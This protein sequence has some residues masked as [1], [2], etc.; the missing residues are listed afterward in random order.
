MV[1]YV[2]LAD[3]ADNG[4]ILLFVIADERDRI[5]LPDPE[6]CAEL[7]VDHDLL[8]RGSQSR[9]ITD[10]AIAAEAVS[11]RVE[12]DIIV[13]RIV[14]CS[15]GVSL[16]RLVSYIL[17]VC[18]GVQYYISYGSLLRAHVDRPL[19][20][21]RKRSD[22]GLVTQRLHQVRAVRRRHIAVDGN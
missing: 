9:K 7:F 8:V 22:P 14:L 19:I 12:I 11:A 21:S 13:K 3:T 18:G 15:R 2:V 5:S 6:E 4:F 20:A 1:V 17:P 16:L 10:L